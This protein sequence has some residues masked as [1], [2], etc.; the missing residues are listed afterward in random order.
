MG[1]AFVRRK[2]GMIKS[3]KKHRQ[4]K[5]KKTNKQNKHTH[6]NSVKM[7]KREKEGD[8]S[9]SKKDK[10]NAIKKKT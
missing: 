7:L 8:M 10:Y 5:D 9:K 2:K 3:Y 4:T 6:V 1:T